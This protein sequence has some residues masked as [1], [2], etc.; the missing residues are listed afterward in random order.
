MDPS[1]KWPLTRGLAL[2]QR[3]ISRFLK[4]KIRP[5]QGSSVVDDASRHSG[6]PA[7]I[8][9]SRNFALSL[10]DRTHSGST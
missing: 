4:V 2:P 8:N 1:R 7:L 6:S 10:G 3:R 5:H 9:A